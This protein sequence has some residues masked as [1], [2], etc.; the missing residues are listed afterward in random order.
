M[1]RMVFKGVE[2][3]GRSFTSVEEV[4]CEDSNP[5]I[6]AIRNAII[7]ANKTAASNWML[8]NPFLKYLLLRQRDD[9]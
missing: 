8:I 9:N 7:A 4:I 6:D 5:I 2:M 1:D 3:R